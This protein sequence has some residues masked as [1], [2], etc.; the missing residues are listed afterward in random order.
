M[1]VCVGVSVRL[2]ACARTRMRICFVCVCAC[3]CARACVHVRG[4]RVCT[5]KQRD[6]HSVRAR[7]CVGIVCVCEC[8]CTTEQRDQHSVRRRRDGRVLW[9]VCACVR[10]GGRVGEWVSG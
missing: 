2:R 1:R 9:C 3:M 5:T 7:A 6:Q 8:V 10:V 4:C